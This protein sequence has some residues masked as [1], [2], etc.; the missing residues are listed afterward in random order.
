VAVTAGVGPG[1]LTCFS[2]HPDKRTADQMAVINIIDLY[3]T[4]SSQKL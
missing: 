4:I 3:C 2:I 1:V